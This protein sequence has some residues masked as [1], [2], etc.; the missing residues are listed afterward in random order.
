MKMRTTRG[1][2]VGKTAEN[3]DTTI[4]VPAALLV[5]FFTAISLSNYWIGRR[6]A[7]EFFNKTAHKR[8]KDRVKKTHQLNQSTPNE[9]IA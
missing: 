7:V 3:G 9:R 8:S 4:N 6:F 2:K 5:G 1:N